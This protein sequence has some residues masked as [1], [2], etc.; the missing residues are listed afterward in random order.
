[1]PK[2]RRGK[3][4][5]NGR[6]WKDNVRL[7][8]GKIAHQG[9]ALAALRTARLLGLVLAMQCSELYVEK[10]SAHNVK[11][12]LH[13]QFQLCH[14][15]R[16]GIPRGV[17]GWG[18]YTCLSCIYALDTSK[19]DTVTARTDAKIQPKLQTQSLLCTSAEDCRKPL[20]TAGSLSIHNCPHPVKSLAICRVSCCHSSILLPSVD[21]KG[22]WA[23]TL[24][25]W[26]SSQ[27]NSLP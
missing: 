25:T 20:F 10:S 12:L 8:T 1:M 22:S 16:N 21:M 24:S 7:L 17:Y 9:H 23:I 19:M 11:G 15:N 4:G 6:L 3:K 5:L 27:A 18:H 26:P 13:C 14:D 2:T